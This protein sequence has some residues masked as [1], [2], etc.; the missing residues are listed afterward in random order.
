MI[1]AV[2]GQRLQTA[3]SRQAYPLLS[4]YIEEKRNGSVYYPNN[5]QAI[6]IGSN[7]QRQQTDYHYEKLS[8]KISHSLNLKNPSGQGKGSFFA[9]KNF[10]TMLYASI[11]QA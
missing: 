6:V 5:D 1:N 3:L 7:P 10:Q 4:E 2:R 11:Q 9:S 8:E